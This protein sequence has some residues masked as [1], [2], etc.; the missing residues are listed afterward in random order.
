M[1]KKIFIRS[2]ISP[3]DDFSISYCISE[4]IYGSNTG[5][6]LYA[7]SIY[8]ALMVDEGVTFWP[9]YYK[10]DL[11]RAEEINETCACF[12]IPLADA[13][14]DDFVYELRNLT[15]MVK[16]LQIPCIVTGVGLKAPYEPDFSTSFSFDDDVRDF[17]NAVLDKSAML[18]LRGELTAQYLKNLGYREEKDFTVIGCPSMY[19]R[20]G[21]LTVKDVTL[22]EHSRV[23]VNSSIRIPHEVNDFIMK[24]KERFSEAYFIPQQ[25]SELRLA[26]TGAPYAGAV[27]YGNYP[28][29]IT[30]PLFAGDRYKAFLDVKSWLAF[31]QKMDFSFGGRLHGNVAAA[32]AGIPNL[33]IVSDARM[34]ELSDYHGLA[35]VSMADMKEE[36]TIFD[37]AKRV[38][39]KQVLKKQK[40]NF[41]HFKE[42]LKINGIDNIY[43][44]GLEEEAP[45]DKLLKSRQE[46]IFK[47]FALCDNEEKLERTDSFYEEFNRVYDRCSNGYKA[48]TGVHE[49][50]M[51]NIEALKIEKDALTLSLKNYQRKNAVSQVV[52]DTSYLP[53]EMVENFMLAVEN[54]FMPGSRRVVH[55]LVK[56]K[57]QSF[58]RLLRCRKAEY[59]D[60]MIEENSNPDVLRTVLFPYYYFEGNMDFW[61]K[62]FAMPEMPESV[63]YACLSD[64]VW[65]IC[66]NVMWPF[67]YSKEQMDK[68]EKRVEDLLDAIPE[69]VFFQYEG[70]DNFL[71]HYLLGMKKSVR[72]EVAVKPEALQL[73][74]DGK[75]VYE[76][77]KLEIILTKFRPSKGKLQFIAF[78]KSPVFR[79]CEK[80]VLYME[81]EKKGGVVERTEIP[82][83]K[84][85]WCFYKC[86]EENNAFYTFVL[87]I[88]TKQ[89]KKFHFYVGLR[90][91][92][93]DTYYYFM[94]EV[95]F[96]TSLN[97]YR[98][99]QGTMEYRFDHNTFLIGKARPEKAEAYCE[100][101]EQQFAQTEPELISFRAQI[102]EKRKEGRKIWL[103]YDCRNVY[104]DNGY[105][106]FVHDF[107][108]KDGI[109]RYYILNNDLDSCR[110]LFTEEHIPFVVPFGSET[111]KLLYCMAEKVITA[112][113]EK[114]NYLP[115]T[116]TEYAKVMDVAS[117]PMLVY[118]QHGVYHAYIPWKYSLDRL[119]LDKK[120]IS[121][122]FEREQDLKNHC[123]TKKYELPVRMPRYDFLNPDIKPEKKI[124]YAPSWRKYLV[125]M[126]DKEWVTRAD[127]FMDS[128]FFR[129][130]SA[131]LRDEALMALLKKN[132]YTLEFKLHPILMRYADCY[133]L[134]GTFVK[135][136]SPAVR[137]EDYAV[138]ITDFSS[139]VFD[140]AY[141]NRAIL[142]FFPDYEEFRSGMSDYRQCVLPFR[143]GMGEFADNAKDAVRM[144]KKIIR[145]GA[146]PGRSQKKL[147]EDMFYY[148]DNGSRERIYESLKSE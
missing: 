24:N 52:L 81:T 113:I 67:H 101:L 39:F 66:N 102:R 75:A 48:M 32:L 70:M 98:Y 42:F 100:R 19:L 144:L 94:P 69:E 58:L 11:D 55:L 90:G 87:S 95:V 59:P 145:R 74:R 46:K 44:R 131:F 76:A 122:K 26:Y 49:N 83:K 105:L 133:Q 117:L 72:T 12:V 54:T 41:E 130:T 60:F 73:L 1:S 8:R 56:R 16:R 13:F 104:K 108:K 109:E 50:D 6:L 115:F 64:M 65:K 35:H 61:E 123:F 14:R 40:P 107:E 110:E 138:F 119:Q 7:H 79:F 135:M 27:K 63:Y 25:T 114:N 78:I 18:G 142:Y 99:Y 3:A 33:M 47:N 71:R 82:L 57:P 112:Y 93:F 126:V 36:D 37:L 29:R 23:C 45:F 89:I 68:A 51:R 85:S 10:I 139:Y 118:L 127:I 17:V 103:Y 43:E 111:H 5:N 129:E 80:P 28:A 96:N 91:V 148:K 124:L 30:D 62:M 106:Q 15:E 97:R 86:K 116:D 136:A 147:M 92:I 2:G 140:F 21:S 141:L 22:T 143:G 4:D 9:N 120:V 128:K 146:K 125:D 38:D 88:N 137:E 20:G 134:D 84:S 121:T 77:K 34:R 31:L 53:D 132:G